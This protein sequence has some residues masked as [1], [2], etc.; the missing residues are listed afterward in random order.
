MAKTL[1]TTLHGLG[2]L[3]FMGETPDGQRVMIDNEKVARTGMSPMQLV[4]NAAGACPVMDVTHML[5]KRRLTVNSYTIDPVGERVHDLPS[6]FTRIKAR[7]ALDV[8]G[9]PGE[10]AERLVDLATNKYCSVGARLKA[11]FEY[12]VVLLHDEEAA[13]RQAQAAEQPA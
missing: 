11:E 6:P 10:E 1:T 5:A 13:A 8:P 2:G 12:E 3:R 7:H 9:L 4:L